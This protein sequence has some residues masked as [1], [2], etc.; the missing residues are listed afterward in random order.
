MVVMGYRMS[1][2]T[3]KLFSGDISISKGS[4]IAAVCVVSRSSDTSGEMMLTKSPIAFNAIAEIGELQHDDP[5]GEEL[6]Y[7][8]LTGFENDSCPFPLEYTPDLPTRAVGSRRTLVGNR[9]LS[10]IDYPTFHNSRHLVIEG[11]LT[12]LL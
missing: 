1:G 10:R 12:T 7:S 9:R 2:W 4:L 11:S 8:K 3:I 5:M 6:I